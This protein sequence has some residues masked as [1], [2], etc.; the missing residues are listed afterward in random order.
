MACSLRLSVASTEVRSTS[1]KRNASAFLGESNMTYIQTELYY[2]YDLYNIDTEQI[3]ATEYKTASEVEA[4]NKQLRANGE[5]QRWIA[6]HF[7]YIDV[8]EMR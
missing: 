2:S 8:D 6:T 1:G 3:E 4:A 5:P 7:G